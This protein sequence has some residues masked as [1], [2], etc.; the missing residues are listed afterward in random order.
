MD[1]YAH[2]ELNLL[3]AQAG[4]AKPKKQQRCD[5]VTGDVL[6]GG[7]YISWRIQGVIRRWTFLCIITALTILVWVTNNPS[8]LLWWN[9]CASYLALV[10]ESVVGIA[11]FS[12]TRRDALVLREVRATAARVE[13]IAKKL[14]KEEDTIEKQLNTI[15]TELE[16]AK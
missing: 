2:A 11:M 6:T 9:L 4:A 13:E 5:P 14:L 1:D 12:Q 15:E 7:E 16:E 10:I 3:H 8:A